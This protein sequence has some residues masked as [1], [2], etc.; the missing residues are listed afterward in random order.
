MYENEVIDAYYASNCGGMSEQVE[1]V[2]PWRS[3]PKP[4][5][6]SQFDGVGTQSIDPQNDIDSWLNTE[7]LSWC[8][9]NIHT[10]LPDWSKANFRWEREV[11]PSDFVAGFAH[12]DSLRILERGASGRIHRL[13]AWQ[14][15]VATELDFELAI[16][17][18]N[19]PP[20]RSSAFTWT[21]TDSSFVF[22]GAGWGHG[23]G[24]CQSGA[25]ARAISG[26]QH[27]D[28]LAHYFPGTRLVAV[29]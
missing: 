10:E 8:N 21:Q 22:K 27:D 1:K 13:Q 7:V 24:M 5:L 25:V 26:I 4:Y 18:M 11:F 2:W 6:I 17:Q 3:G 14:Q 29:F 12:V 15:G 9:P 28:I 23:V 20:L 19:H 16:R